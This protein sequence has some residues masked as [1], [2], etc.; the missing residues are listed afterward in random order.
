MS[1][2]AAITLPDFST[3]T[4]NVILYSSG[5]GCAKCH[6]AKMQ[7]KSHNIPFVEVLATEDENIMAYLRDMGASS[8]PVIFS[9]DLA[10][11]W[12]MRMDKLEELFSLYKPA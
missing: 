7:L 12:D 9:R 10:P 3:I 11:F 2:T 5:P 4:E 8:F 1:T 6:I